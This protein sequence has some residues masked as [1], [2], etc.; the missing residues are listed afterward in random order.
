MAMILELFL[1]VI[2]LLAI[3]AVFSESISVRLANYALRFSFAL[4]LCELTIS[5][6]KVF[7]FVSLANIDSIFIGDEWWNLLAGPAV[8]LLYIY[9]MTEVSIYESRHKSK[10]REKG[11]AT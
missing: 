11:Q 1:I 7:K 8:F 2:P 5:W 3:F 4:L 6:L 10:D 9:V